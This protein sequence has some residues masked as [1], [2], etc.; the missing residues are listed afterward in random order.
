MPIEKDVAEATC[1]LEGEQWSGAGIACARENEQRRCK[2]RET[3]L[4]GR[5]YS[6]AAHVLSGLNEV[7]VL[8]IAAVSS[9]R[10]FCS[11]MPS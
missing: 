1:G 6:T 2:P 5:R 11:T 8:A 3:R 4:A 7:M 10:S 9:P